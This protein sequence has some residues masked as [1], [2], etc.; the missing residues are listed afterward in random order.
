MRREEP[1][2]R[3]IEWPVQFSRQTVSISKHEVGSPLGS[4]SRNV[5]K[6][7]SRRLCESHIFTLGAVH[8]K[9]RLQRGRPEHLLVQDDHEY[10]LAVVAGFH[11]VA[12]RVE[13]ADS[14]E[15]RQELIEFG[16]VQRMADQGPQ[17]F[18]YWSLGI[19]LNA[20]HVDRLRY[21]RL[22]FLPRVTLRQKLLPLLI[23]HLQLVQNVLFSFRGTLAFLD[24]RVALLVV[25]R[26][27]I[28]EVH[29]HHYVRAC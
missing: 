23:G 29:A 27:E 10:L 3:R 28:L 13:L 2:A 11:A 24:D 5:E 7:E 16:P 18:Q 6:C 12:G 1:S 20:A 4:I 21:Y 26:R 9:P 22:D 19:G 8:L 15:S 25:K 17:E 14:G